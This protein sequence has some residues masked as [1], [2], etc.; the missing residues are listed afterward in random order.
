MQAVQEALTVKLVRET[1]EADRTKASENEK[2][3]R[4]MTLERK[5]KQEQ[6]LQMEIIA[7][8]TRQYKSVEEE[9]LERINNLSTR[10][11]LN[12]QEIEK[13]QDKK[14]KLNKEIEE[15]KVEKE[16]KIKELQGNIDQMS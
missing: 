9:M 2:R 8:M 6:K 7:D 5:V 15:M 12:E 14:S 4:F 11:S 1:E 13:L 3:L 10:G 16:V